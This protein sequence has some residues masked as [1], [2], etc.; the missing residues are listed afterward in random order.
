MLPFA[1]LHFIRRDESLDTEIFERL[2]VRLAEVA[3]ICRYLGRSLP[4][5]LSHLLDERNQ[6]GAICGL[7]RKS[8]ADNDLSLRIHR[9]LTIV[10]LNEGLILIL[11]DPGFRVGKVAL[12]F[13]SRLYLIRLLPFRGFTSFALRLFFL[14]RFLFS[15]FSTGFLL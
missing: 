15:S 8:G 10:P 6:M 13:R 12:R 1:V 5:I 3:G 11:H 4:D 9:K 2:N 7:I 14:L